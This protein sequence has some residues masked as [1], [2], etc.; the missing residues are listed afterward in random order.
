MTPKEV[1]LLLKVYFIDYFRV[2]PNTFLDGFTPGGA[3]ASTASVHLF[4]RCLNC[5]KTVF[6]FLVG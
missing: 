5:K 3:I 1:F 2:T 4:G 6:Y